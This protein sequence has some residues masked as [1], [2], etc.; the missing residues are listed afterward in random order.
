MKLAIYDFDGTYMKNQ[1][2]P[3]IFKFWKEQGLNITIYRKLW[4]K[5]VWRYFLHKYNLFGWNKQTFRVNAMSLTADL[6]RSVDKEVLDKFLSDLYNHL[7]QY[8]NLELK[9]QLQKDKEEGFYT[10]LLS[11]N[12]DIILEPFLNEG[13]DEVIGSTVL[14]NG[15]VIPSNEVEIIIHDIKANKMK[16][17]FP[18][19]DYKNSI[20]YADSYYDL[21]ILE[22]VG[23]P[24]V[25][26]PDEELLA[27]AKERLYKIFE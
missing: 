16:E 23:N 15:K 18:Q 21:P 9:K 24:I 1:V 11:G 4:R 5:I 20:A 12:F 22:I 27:L 2:L 19:A 8:I 25:V 13:F 3:L 7:K 26:N 10:V 14:K 17:K 6:F